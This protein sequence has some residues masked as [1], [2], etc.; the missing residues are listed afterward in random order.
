MHH[1]S[2][3]RCLA[4]LGLSACTRAPASAGPAAVEHTP[5]PSA[6]PSGLAMHRPIPEAVDVGLHFEVSVDQWCGAQLDPRGRTL[7]HS[8]SF[9][10]AWNI[11]VVA[12]QPSRNYNQPAPETEDQA[13]ALLC[14]ATCE[15][16][17]PRVIRATRAGRSGLGA[18]LPAKRGYVVVPV[19]GGQGSCEFE[20]TITVTPVGELLHVSVDVSDGEPERTY[21]HG[22]FDGHYGYIPAYGGCEPQTITRT[23]L[24]IDLERGEL[25]LSVT[26]TRPASAGPVAVEVQPR[27]HGVVLQGCGERLELAWTGDP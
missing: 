24:L 10:E 27:E 13:R 19:A 25:E 2:L 21:F 4:A 12:A 7:E 3:L 5:G 9:L 26:Q 20:P 15:Q 14:G 16:A 22:E 23:D 17:R 11:V 8:A 1:P 18:M 6:E